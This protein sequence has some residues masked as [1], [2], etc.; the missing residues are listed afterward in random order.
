[1]KKAA[2]QPAVSKVSSEW[3]W[4]DH[5]GQIRC[6]ISSLRMRYTVGP[7]L[8]AVG[9]PDRESDVFVTANYKLS[10]DILRRELKG[11]NAW[12]IV[13]DTKGINVWCAAGKGTFGTD[14]LISRINEINLHNVVAH[15]R[16]IVPQLGAVGVNARIVQQRT[17]FRVYFGPVHA[18]DIPAYIRAGYI[19]T[20]EMR[21]VRFNMMDRLVLT[22]MEIN[23]AMKKFPLFGLII[24][25]L[26]GIQPSGILFK[27]AWEEGMPFLIFGL[28]AVFSG[29]FMTPLLLPFI[30]FR[31]F[32]VKG[33]LTGVIAVFALMQGIGG[34]WH[35]SSLLPLVAAYIFFPLASSYIALQFTGSTTFTNMS[36][37][38]KELKIGVPVYLT[39]TATSLLILVMYR[40]SQWGII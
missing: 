14:E 8:Y 17:G 2:G 13:L 24:L 3:T 16:I 31:S 12:I 6:R 28:T 34:F 10:F 38:K 4:T 11:L 33:W 7:G 9:E 27:D 39:A 26:F 15:R 20:P 19:K 22:P 18:K 21:L 32:A 36:G 40:L 29:A 30:P 23:P 5:F 1:M 25:L 35:Y 37:V